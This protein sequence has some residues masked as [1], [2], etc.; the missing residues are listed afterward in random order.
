MNIQSPICVLRSN[1]Y[2]K[3]KDINNIYFRQTEE[4]GYIDS[5]VD[6]V[7]EYKTLCGTRRLPMIGNTH[8]W[9]PQSYKYNYKE[10]KHII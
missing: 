1:I 2:N 8:I 9:V 6:A 3:V 5:T 4:H 10:Y 7:H